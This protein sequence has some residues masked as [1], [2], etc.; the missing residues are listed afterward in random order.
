MTCIFDECGCGVKL[1]RM[2][3]AGNVSCLRE[4]RMRRQPRMGEIIWETYERVW[5]VVHVQLI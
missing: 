1:G 3:L 2:R 4:I 5:G